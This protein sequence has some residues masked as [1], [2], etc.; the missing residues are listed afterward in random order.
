VHTKKP[1]KITQNHAKLSQEHPKKLTKYLV[2]KHPKKSLFLDQSIWC[3]QKKRKNNKQIQEGWYQGIWRLKKQGRIL[4][5]LFAKRAQNPSKIINFYASQKY[6][7]ICGPQ[8]IGHTKN[9]LKIIQNQ[10]KL[11]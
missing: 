7:N 4:K 6:S 11:P 3:M 10:A 5:L 1:L 9:P 8:E 2:F